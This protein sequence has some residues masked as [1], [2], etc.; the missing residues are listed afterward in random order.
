MTNW[1]S[2]DPHRPRKPASGLLSIFSTVAGI[3]NGTNPNPEVHDGTVGPQVG[4]RNLFLPATG[5]CNTTSVSAGS[6][7][8]AVASSATRPSNL[9]LQDF[10]A[11]LVAPLGL[12]LQSKTA[13]A[14]TAQVGWFVS[15]TATHSFPE[16]S[17]LLVVNK[18]ILLLL[19]RQISDRDI[20]LST[21]RNYVTA[22]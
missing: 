15:Q 14:L 2:Q 16:L 18:L 1:V 17:E 4:A 22:L 12:Y 20:T 11:F 19:R 3:R 7:S 5:S 10:Q 21:V 6:P 9:I 8:V 13:A